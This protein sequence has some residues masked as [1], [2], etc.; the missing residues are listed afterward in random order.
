MKR[1][2]LESRDSASPL[3]T[4]AVAAAL[5][6]RPFETYR[7]TW[8]QKALLT[9]MSGMPPGLAARAIAWDTT[10]AG[11]PPSLA[12]GLRL[13]DLIH[14]RLADYRALPGP[15]SAVVVGAALGGAAAHLSVA[16]GAPFL[17]QA[18]VL[19]FRG[20]SPYDSLESHLVNAQ[21]LATPILERNPG[22]L[23]ISHF[24]PLH[25]GWL[26]PHIN[27]L[28]LKLL[29]LPRF[30]RSFLLQRLAPGGTIL[31]LDCGARWLQYALNPLH[32]YQIG[33]WG[34]IPA[35]EFLRGSERIDAA[36][37]AR[38]S[39][40]RGGW[41]VKGIRPQIFPE[42][43]WGSEPAFADAL[44]G[45]T[46]ETG[47]RFV[48]LSFPEPHDFSRL[49]FR[50]YQRL[51]ERAG[52]AP[53]G[54]LVETFS[55]YDPYL[56]ERGRLLPLWLVFNTLDSLAFLQAMR[57]HFPDGRPVFFCPLVTFSRPPD[58]VPW[59]RWQA[60]LEGLPWVNVGAR[61][62]RYPAD[63]VALWRWQEWLR[64]AMGPLDEGETVPRLEVDD[65]QRLAGELRADS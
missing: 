15:F 22:V 29:E 58:M 47:F 5:A 65:L 52:R 19:S 33:G 54:V 53:R 9:L 25:D 23:A 36:L 24:D 30:Y 38:K 20:G 1:G 60:A 55:Q 56:V 43:E 39:P 62:N 27:H 41:H 50:A 63:L 45:F 49:A 57:P 31:Y 44:E 35:E 46:R 6:G 64:R 14:E 2:R 17:P 12:D 8:W 34:G 4:R 18:F 26:T 61:A 13:A 3:L 21:R 42:S 7:L 40:H 32:R 10:R 11:L 28:R 59:E 51:W 16:L 37:A 48:R